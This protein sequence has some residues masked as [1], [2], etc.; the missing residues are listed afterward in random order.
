M[1]KMDELIREFLSQ[2]NIAVAGI[3]RNDKQG[4]GNIIY[5]K[6]KDSGYNVYPVH[7]ALNIYE[8][9]KCYPDVKS[10]TEKIDG[11]VIATAPS[12]TEKIVSDCIAAGIN[13]VWI[14]N[15]FGIKGVNKPKTSLTDK[16]VQLCLDNNISIIPGGCP[17]MFCE[18]VDFGHKCLRGITRLIGGFRF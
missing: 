8:G 10:I 9:E 11:V 14:H 12:I 6:L 15:M 5:K 7:P 2:K 13:R 1:S 3:K 18:P 16:A 17:M 4:V